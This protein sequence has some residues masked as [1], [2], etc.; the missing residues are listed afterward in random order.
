MATVTME[1]SLMGVIQKKGWV[2]KFEAKGRAEGGKAE[3]YTIATKM[4]K[5]N[6]P[7]DEIV[8]D[9]GLSYDEIKGILTDIGTSVT[10]VD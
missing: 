7:I 5:R 4:L 1:E 10:G 6:R 2:D 9:T 8:E 3:R